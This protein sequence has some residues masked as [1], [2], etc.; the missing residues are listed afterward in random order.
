MIDFTHPKY[1]DHISIIKRMINNG[2]SI[3]DI[4]T[5]GSNDWLNEK[6]LNGEISVLIS[7]GDWSLLVTEVDA[8]NK[9]DQDMVGVAR[10]GEDDSEVGIEISSDVVLPSAEGS[11][12]MRYKKH[13]LDQGWYKDSVSQLGINAVATLRRMSRNTKNR[14]QGAIKGLV[15]GHVQS[16]KTANIASMMSVGADNGWNFFI[17]LSGTIESL[18]KQTS[19]RIFGDLNHLG[20]LHW[21][22]L[23][24]LGSNQE[25]S[26]KL[27]NLLLN[28]KSVNRYFT[29]SL[30]VKSRLEKLIRWLKSDER[31]LNQMK[32]V[33]VDD[34]ADQASIN[35]SIDE[36]TTINRLIIELT[37][38]PALAVNYVA[39]TATPYSCFLNEAFQE[40]LYPSDFI[41]TLKQSEEHFGPRQIFG[42]EGQSRGL[43][44][45][46]I[47]PKDTD[48][49]TGDYYQILE[50][51]QGNTSELPQS[52]KDSLSW[53]ICCSAIR[54]IQGYRKPVS[55]LI[56]TSQRQSHHQNIA[57]AVLDWLRDSQIEVLSNCLTIYEEETKRFGLE[58]FKEQFPS[59]RLIQ[60]I[61]TYPKYS[62]L[63]QTIKEVVSDVS[64]IFYME[65][66]QDLK[67]KFS[68]GI[69]LCIDNSANNGITIENEHIRLLYP[70][71]TNSV[72]WS[73]SFIVVG[74]NT[75]SRGLTLEGLVSTYFL[76]N[77]YQADTLMQVGRWF[78]YRR[79]YELLPRIWLTDDTN[80]KFRFL[81]SL[82]E[83]LRDDLVSFQ[84]DRCSPREYGPRVKTHH[85][86]SVLSQ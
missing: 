85:R 8:Q 30:K 52:L 78:G 47:I 58:E 4:K 7:S 86:T 11:S 5:L 43:D 12:W 62:D 17:I 82:E 25:D 41:K 73:T 26:H 56:H 54:R 22:Q 57:N 37:K 3:I 40:S 67:I 1:D 79:G 20:N 64:H 83:E 35:T 24:H 51:H 6:Y 45:I 21:Y 15:V 16:G 74:G 65:D 34:E 50:I 14:Q 81:V 42:I 68:K 72:D 38:M 46:R 27:Q 55:M 53:F 48:N 49:K 9:R 77:L 63:V 10:V 75:L 60:D 66:R 28:S 33:I 76:R 19:S 71:S 84:E 44:I 2:K 32:L 23:S 29:V 31:K 70:D 18:R 36:R 39:Y 69:N 13:L 59:Y 80:E 61:K